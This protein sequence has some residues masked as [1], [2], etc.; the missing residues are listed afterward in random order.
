MPITVVHPQWHEGVWAWTGKSGAVSGM[1]QL[2]TAKMCEE[3][4]TVTDAEATTRRV[5]RVG[6]R[7]A[8]ERPAWV[9][10][11]QLLQPQ[12]LRLTDT[13]C[14]PLPEIIVINCDRFQSLI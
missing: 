5:D 10:R 6:E 8:R 3:T 13:V 9:S 14:D 2:E 7:P 11:L 1:Q 12:S 4:Q